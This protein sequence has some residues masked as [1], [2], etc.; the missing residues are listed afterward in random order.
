MSE[1]FITE[2]L[3]D[4]RYIKADLLVNRFRDHIFDALGETSR[5]IIDDHENLFEPDVELDSEPFG[6]GGRTLS[7]LR[8]EFDL[9]REHEEFGPLKLNIGVEWVDPDEQ[10]E[11]T[12]GDGS[13]C[14]VYYKIQR[15]SEASFNAVE[16]RT[17]KED[18]WESIHF[19]A[20]QWPY[21]R[22]EAPGI[23][24]IPVGDGPG[25]IEGLETLRQHFSEEYVPELRR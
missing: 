12:T 4:D 14:Y 19:G 23:V 21:R 11:P 16:Q 22:K 2:G 20:D 8:V 9:R 6:T 18:E 13:L 5:Q 25:L 10:D 3:A 24:Y 15:G 1:D 7:T 17:A